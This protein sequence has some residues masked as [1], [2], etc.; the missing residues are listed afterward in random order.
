MN[1]T[2]LFQQKAAPGSWGGSL[3]VGIRAGCGDSPGGSPQINQCLNSEAQYPSIC[4]TS[5][6]GSAT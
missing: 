4:F 1:F 2:G 5:D 6:G 3:I